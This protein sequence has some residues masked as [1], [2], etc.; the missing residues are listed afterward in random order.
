MARPAT[1][2]YSP[3]IRLERGASS[4]TVY[5]DCCLM[6]RG[7]A[8]MHGLSALAIGYC[9][10]MRVLIVLVL[11]AA[12]AAPVTPDARYVGAATPT[13][14]SAVCRAGRAVLRVREGQAV[15]TPDETTWTL[16]GTATAGGALQAERVGHGANRQTYVTRFT[17]TWSELAASGVYTTPKCSYNIQLERR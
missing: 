10:A 8:P 15:F 9:S 12:C 16:V 5:L 6:R 2:H 11:L 17:G 13:T 4:R 1:R 14:A 3:L 7:R